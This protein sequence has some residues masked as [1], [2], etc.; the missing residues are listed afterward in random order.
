[1]FAHGSG[2][3]LKSVFQPGPRTE[4]IKSASKRLSEL[5]AAPGNEIQ[6]FLMLKYIPYRKVLSVPQNATSHFRTGRTVVGCIL[7]W[8]NNTPGIEQTAKLAA[9]ELT[10]IFT[11]A[12]SQ[13][14]DA[15]KAGYGNFSKY[16]YP[17]LKSFVARTTEDASPRF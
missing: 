17:I 9:H 4:L 6:H 3:Y 5:N 12:D 7:K 14:S 2:Y 11:A 15:S 1:V 16:R 13:I 10:N 8:T